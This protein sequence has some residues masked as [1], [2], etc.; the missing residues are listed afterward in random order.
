MRKNIKFGE[1]KT[2]KLNTLLENV[3][4]SETQDRNIEIYEWEG[5]DY[6]N[7]AKI[8]KYLLNNNNDKSFLTKPKQLFLPEYHFYPKEL[9]DIL[10]KE[11]ELYE[12]GKQLSDDESKKKKMHIEMGYTN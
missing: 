9:F 11:N 6:K 5:E 2:K 8:E 4:L 12:N 3:T 10:R 7:K 1:E